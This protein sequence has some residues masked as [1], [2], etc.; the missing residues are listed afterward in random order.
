MEGEKDMEGWPA[1][2]AKDIKHVEFGD[3]IGMSR[4]KRNFKKLSRQEKEY[5]FELVY[6][7][8]DMSS[9]MDAI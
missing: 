3:E 7:L 4:M 1:A 2:C 9:C 8:R 6:L 5:V